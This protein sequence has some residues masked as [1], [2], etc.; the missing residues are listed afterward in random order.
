M[1]R[2]CGANGREPCQRGFFNV[3][4]NREQTT[5]MN[6]RNFL[7]ATAASAAMLAHVPGLRA[8]TY[9]LIVKGGHVIDPSL[10]INQDRY[11]ATSACRIAAVEARSAADVADTRH[12]RTA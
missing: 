12:A 3:A 1:R 10:R 7:L 8:A 6:R 4:K 2:P 5:M 9:D 11:V